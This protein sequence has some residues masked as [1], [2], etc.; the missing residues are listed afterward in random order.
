GIVTERCPET[1]QVTLVGVEGLLSRL[2]SEVS[3][4]RLCQRDAAYR[5]R[6]FDFEQRLRESRLRVVLR[7]L[8]AVA[9][10]PFAVHFSCE[11]PCLALGALAGNLSQPLVDLRHHASP[12]VP[13][14]AA[15][16][17]PTEARPSVYL[18]G[19]A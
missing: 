11:S 3:L 18:L 8:G 13:V 2:R 4:R 14:R 16:W 10:P 9:L 12:F 6:R 5:L 7:P 1:Q 15:G 19:R 17:S